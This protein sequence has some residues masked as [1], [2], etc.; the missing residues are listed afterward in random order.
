MSVVP[1]VEQSSRITILY[2]KLATWK[3]HKCKIID[4]KKRL[5]DIEKMQTT[6]DIQDSKEVEIPII[7]E[8]EPVVPETDK[9]NNQTD[10][11]ENP[12]DNTEIPEEPQE[13]I[14]KYIINYVYSVNNNIKESNVNDKLAVRPVVYLKSRILLISGDGSFNSPYV[15]K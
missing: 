4:G 14:N 6:R 9:E 11:E 15:V 5:T 3:C 1:S 12:E 7:E 2:E 10:E 13:E 8:P